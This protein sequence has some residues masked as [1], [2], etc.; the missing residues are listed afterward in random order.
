MVIS[1]VYD[2]E[3]KELEW[4]YV[5]LTRISPAKSK[6]VKRLTTDSNGCY[7]FENLRNGTY[8]VR[9]K[10]CTD[11]GAQITA[12]TGGSKVNNVNFTCR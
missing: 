12:V 2:I 1:K 10:S 11:G 9:V 7:H 4:K 3:D 8:K 6:V 5:V